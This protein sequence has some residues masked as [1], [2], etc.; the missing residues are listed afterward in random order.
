MAD[1][2]KQ[3]GAQKLSLNPLTALSLYPVSIIVLSLAID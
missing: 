1:I 3:L 2:P